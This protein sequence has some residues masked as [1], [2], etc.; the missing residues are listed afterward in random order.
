MTDYFY[1]TSPA[2]MLDIE[3][4]FEN[5]D[6]GS[7]LT[8]TFVV[9]NKSNTYSSVKNVTFS[10][11]SNKMNINVLYRNNFGYPVGEYEVYSAEG[12]CRKILAALEE[13]ED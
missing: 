2:S 8:T 7:W 4:Y 13:A 11:K 3:E 6:I 12:I 9:Y 1:Y 5:F 10:L